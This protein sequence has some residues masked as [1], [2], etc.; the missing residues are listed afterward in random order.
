MASANIA[1]LLLARATGASG[2]SSRSDVALGAYG[3]PAG[4]AAPDREP[5][6]LDDRRRRGHD[7]RLVDVEHHRHRPAAPCPFPIDRSALS[8]D[9]RVLAFTADSQSSPA[10]CSAWRRRFQPTDRTSSRC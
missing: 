8:L 5:A 2:A 1:N 7:P 4:A 10:S 6:A 9:P 3:G